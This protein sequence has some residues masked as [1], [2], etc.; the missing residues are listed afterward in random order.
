[1]VFMKSLVNYIDS[2][3]RDAVYGLNVQLAVK[4]QTM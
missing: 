2:M 1:M 4:I 3:C